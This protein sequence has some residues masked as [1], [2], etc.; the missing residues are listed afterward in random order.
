MSRCLSCRRRV[1]GMRDDRSEAAE[2]LH[3]RGSSAAARRRP[4][5]RAAGTAAPAR[6]AVAVP[7]RACRAAAPGR[8]ESG[9]SAAAPGRRGRARARG[10]RARRRA[11]RRGRPSAAGVAR[12]RRRTR[13]PR[14]GRK[15]S[16]AGS[17]AR[18]A[19]TSRARRAGVSRAQVSGSSARS[20]PRRK[21]LCRVR[22][23]SRPRSCAIVTSRDAS[24][25]GQWPGQ[26]GRALGADGIAEVGLDD[27]PRHR[28]LE[29]ERGHA[30]SATARRAGRMRSPA[31]HS[32]RRRRRSARDARVADAVEPGAEQLEGDA[33]EVRAARQGPLEQRPDRIGNG[34]G[35]GVEIE[36][37]EL[38]AAG[39]VD[40]ADML[41][42]ELGEH[43]RGVEAV[44]AR[45]GVDV[46]QVEHQ[47]AAALPAERVEEGR[48]VHLARRDVEV[49]DVVLEQ[50]RHRHAL[51]HLADARHQQLDGFA[52]ARQRQGDADVHQRVAV[53]GE[54]KGQVVAVPGKAEA[55]APALD[56]LDMR[57]IERRRRCRST[58]RCR[59]RRAAGRGSPARAPR[60][61]RGRRCSAARRVR[62]RSVQRMSGT[63]ST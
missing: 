4:C 27:Q 36:A 46:V 18:S 3:R 38:H 39:D 21:P 48:L 29:G 59:G 43:R 56:L 61:R 33:A 60:G 62:P 17:P 44:V 8:G 16:P 45:V 42:L 47:A 2:A 63:I 53:L 14:A 1:R 22:F 58:G 49:V 50:E 35:V 15:S 23:M 40:L 7:P 37:V 54:M 19:A 9:R 12:G 25:G 20:L 10:W 52:V 11:P 28:R 32:A 34:V 57:R 41:E 55:A 24:S 13:A 26:R 51:L 30:G 31:V 5:C 6:S